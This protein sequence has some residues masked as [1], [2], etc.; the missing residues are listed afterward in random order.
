MI[1]ITILTGFLGSGKT[2]FLNKI[3]EQNPKI[4][5]G[6]IINEFGEVGIDG[7]LVES[8]GQELVE[9][10]NGCVCCV[11][12]KDLQDTVS[13][14]VESGKVD[15]IIIEASGLAEP[16]PVAQTFAMDDLGGKVKLDAV[17]CLV[18]SLNYQVTKETYQTAVEQIEFA[19]ILVLN[20]TQEQD[21]EKLEI[22]N[23]FIKQI[24]PDAT[25]LENSPELDTKVLIETGAWSDEKLAGQEEHHHDH[26]HNEVDEVVFT[27]SEILDPLKL[28]NWIRTEFPKNVI[29]A[30]GFLKLNMSKL[31]LNFNGEYGL[32]LFQMVGARKS[33]EPFTKAKPDFDYSTSRL[34]LIGK[35]LDKTK[36]IED[37]EKTVID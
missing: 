28:D 29:R 4:K 6:L 26:E 18:D 24:N 16:A 2:T 31:D 17:I 1:P 7:Q 19:D 32:F 35:D 14:L 5:F 9:M 27:T 10:S 33:L 12:R 23:K 25:I 3:I 30:K 11:V 22:L 13:K 34:V 37:L 8:S 36:I 15:Y 20:K 21:T